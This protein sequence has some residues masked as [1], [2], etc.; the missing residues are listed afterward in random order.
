MLFLEGYSY[1]GIC[2][3]YDDSAILGIW[4]QYLGSYWHGL[5]KYG[6]SQPKLLGKL[7]MGS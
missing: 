5:W 7:R 3:A 1:F 2:Q 6:N 4:D